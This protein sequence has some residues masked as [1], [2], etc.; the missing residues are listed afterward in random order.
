MR[1]ALEVERMVKEGVEQFILKEATID[2]FLRT[3]RSAAGDNY[4]YSHQ[5]TQSLF[6]KIVRQALMKR[7]KRLQISRRAKRKSTAKGTR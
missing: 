5:L 2:D 1:K 7:T 4:V 6:S 3:L